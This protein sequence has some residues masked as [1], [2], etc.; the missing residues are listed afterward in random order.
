M[1]IENL[2]FSYGEKVIFNGF[3]MEIPRYSAIAIM[4]GSGTGKTTLAN[5]ICRQLDFDGRIDGELSKIACVFQQ[6]RLIP[7]MSVEDNIKFVLPKGMDKGTVDQK[8]DEVITNLQLEDCRKSYPKQISGGQASRV[9]IARALVVDSDVLVFDEP[10]KG[11]DVSLKRDIIKILIHLIKEKT[12][13]FITHDPEEALAIADE[14]YVFDRNE[15][16]G[17]II[18][19]KFQITQSKNSRDMYGDY[20]NK[21]RQELYENI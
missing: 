3:N 10:F 12:V 14:V 4:G 18:K 11:L 17:V 16:D 9:A 20:I 21:L 15:G 6:S 13:I 5:C 7:S 19:D 1:K 2:S 8:L